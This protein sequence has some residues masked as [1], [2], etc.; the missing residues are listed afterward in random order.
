M[1]QGRGPWGG[2]GGA[3]SSDLGAFDDGSMGEDLAEVPEAVRLLA[4]L[5]SWRSIA[6]GFMVSVPGGSDPCRVLFWLP[7]P[8][9]SRL[10]WSRRGQLFCRARSPP[11]LGASSLETKPLS[12][13]PSSPS[14]PR[15][16]GT[17]GRGHHSDGHLSRQPLWQPLMQPF[18]APPLPPACFPLQSP[19]SRPEPFPRLE[20]SCA[21]LAVG[22][23]A[24]AVGRR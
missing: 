8:L 18:L 23:P 1:K 21:S 3:L 12:S 13:L 19:Q 9:G 17:R 22:P 14:F 5:R 15:A 16:L 11:A 2:V 10:A 7:C 24:L 4:A 20:M 6:R